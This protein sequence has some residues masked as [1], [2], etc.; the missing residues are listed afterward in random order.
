MGQSLLGRIALDPD[1][2]DYDVSGDYTY[3][4]SGP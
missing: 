3:S 2:V 4:S 1:G